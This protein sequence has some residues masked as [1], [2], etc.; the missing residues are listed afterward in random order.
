MISLPACQ[1]AGPEPFTAA[2]LGLS[3]RPILEFMPEVGAN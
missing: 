3:R 2:H 1:P